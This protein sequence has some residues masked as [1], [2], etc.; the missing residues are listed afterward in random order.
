MSIVKNKKARILLGLFA[1]LAV[2]AAAIAYWTASGTGSGTASVGSDS[3]VT[4]SGVSFSGSLY[5]GGSATVTF[6]V[7]NTSTTSSVKVDKVIQDGDVTGLPANCSAS[8]FSFDDAS[9]TEE[10]AKSDSVTK[11]GTLHMANTSDN[12]N[13]CKGASPVLHLKTDNSGI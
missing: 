13:A 4:I 10:I 7:N 9:V 5:P 6:T 3:G 12:Q 11:T 8:D 1:A 2:T